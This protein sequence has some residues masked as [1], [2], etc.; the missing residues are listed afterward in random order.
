[1]AAAKELAD[2]LDDLTEED[3]AKLK[4]ALDDISRDGPR[5]E[6]GAARVKKILSKVGGGIGNA[7]Y[8]VAVDVASEAAKKV[9]TGGL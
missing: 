7:L 1:M 9:L 4:G 8:K 5:S 3:R 6:V 2:E